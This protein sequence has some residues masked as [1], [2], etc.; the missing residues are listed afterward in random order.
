M[1]DT[2]ISY[3]RTGGS[4]YAVR[5]YDFLAFRN[6][7]PFYDKTEMENGRFDE[8]I[9]NNITKALNFIL[10]LSKNALDRCTNLDDWVRIE[11]E[12]A[13]ANNSNIIIL[14]EDA[15]CY[16]DELPESIQAL[17]R[18]QA[19]LF[20][21]KSFTF[22][23]ELLAQSLKVF[24]NADKNTSLFVAD[25]FN[26]A[27]KY[28]TQYED[29]DR[30]RVIVRKAPAILHKFGHNVWGYTSF[31]SQKWKLKGK[32]YGK[33]RLAGIYYANGYLDDGFG[34][35]FLELKNN[36]VLEG[37]WSGYDSENK[38][39][40]TGKYIFKKRQ[41]KIIIRSP[42]QLDFAYMARILDLQLGKN[43]ITEDVFKDVIDNEKK[44]YCKV[45]EDV[46]RH[47]I[48]GVCLYAVIDY[49]AV[50]DLTHGN[51]IT[52]LKFVP[53]IGL[54]KTIAIDEAYKNLGLASELVQNVLEELTKKS[55]TCCISPAWKH[56]GVTNIAN[57]LERNN[58]AKVMEIPDYWY[59][60]SINE[61]FECPHCGNP[62]HCSCVIYVKI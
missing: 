45:I 61:K 14:Q 32:I 36:G 3:R 20:D 37:F 18:Y 27:G 55:I 54:I 43:Y 42:K 53:Q 47:Q 11:I 16:P 30:G 13:I 57:V 2:F 5:V 46:A 23:L 7:R 8:Q 58:F 49:K 10:I 33:K 48:V 22:K 1:F 34:T 62:C 26:F 35:F 31:D 6:F 50:Q 59:E 56:V 51:N 17:R 9:K 52:E 41:N 19:I 4:Y 40:T 21:D 24:S 29:M 28:L 60:S 15:F 44:S 12:L 25:R 39:I 38:N